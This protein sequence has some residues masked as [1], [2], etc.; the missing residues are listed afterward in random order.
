[1]AGA[2]DYKRNFI[3]TGLE[4]L[5]KSLSELEPKFQKKI[6]RQ[7]QRQGAK[8][9]LKKAKDKAPKETGALKKAIKIKS[10][11]RS[12]KFV[13]ID[14]GVGSQFF[15]GKQ[16][17]GSFLE[18]GWKPG[19]TGEFI[20]EQHSF[21]KPTFEEEGNNVKTKVMNEMFNGLMKLANTA[22]GK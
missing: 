13:G 20:G 10:A 5:D 4:E 17:Y 22:G 3:V 6:V 7:A 16:F 8:I 14:I 1:M 9:L 11:P 12:R 18:F 19:G 2:D 21:I 15:V